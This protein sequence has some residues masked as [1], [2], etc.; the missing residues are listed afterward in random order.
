MIIIINSTYP[1]QSVKEIA[2]RFK[3]EPALP[4]YISEIVGPY[5][6]FVK[7]VGRES[8]RI[9]E[10]DESRYSEAIEYLSKRVA[11]YSEVPGFSC[12][13]QP[14]TEAKESVKWFD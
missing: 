13:M 8:I 14:W 10:F 11:T 7:V 12:E 1:L 4:E 5:T 2:K 3:E 9:F 6:R